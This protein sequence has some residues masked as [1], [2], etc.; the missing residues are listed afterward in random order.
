M[1]GWPWPMFSLLDALARVPADQCEYC[2]ADPEI[3]CLLHARDGD[4]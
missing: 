3:P 1:S 2:A 4:G